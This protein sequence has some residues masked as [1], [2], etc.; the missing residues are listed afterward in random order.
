MEHHPKP[1]HSGLFSVLWVSGLEVRL[2]CQAGAKD[3][4]V[5]VQVTEST[6]EYS[7]MAKEC[8]AQ[9]AG[10]GKGEEVMLTSGQH[11]LLST[12]GYLLVSFNRAW[13]RTR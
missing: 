11:H 12:R 2:F 3:A 7:M 13:N 10:P 8:P 4:K 6:V 5:P 1:G 9:G